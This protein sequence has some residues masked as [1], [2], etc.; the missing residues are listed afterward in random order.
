MVF[1]DNPKIYFSLRAKIFLFNLCKKYEF[2]VFSL[3]G[4]NEKISIINLR[5]SRRGGEFL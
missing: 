5:G 4:R 2:K 3:P 1:F